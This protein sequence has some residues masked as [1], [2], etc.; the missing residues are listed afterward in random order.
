MADYFAARR[1]EIV[2]NKMSG[3]TK[4]FS[5]LVGD[6]DN[7]TTDLLSE[8]KSADNSGYDVEDAK[9]HIASAIEAFNEFKARVFLAIHELYKAQVE[10]RIKPPSEIEQSANG[11][12]QKGGYQ[13]PDRPYASSNDGDSDS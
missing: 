3:F 6:I 12:L 8:I 13:I 10:H 4:N 9:L 7:L 1:V 5:K 11:Q 2:M